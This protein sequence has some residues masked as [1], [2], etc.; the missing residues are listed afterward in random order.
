[1]EEYDGLIDFQLFDMA[2]RLLMMKR[3]VSPL[4]VYIAPQMPSGIYITRVFFPDT[5][6]QPLIDKSFL[7][8]SLN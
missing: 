4:D 3:G 2:G 5:R 1:L 8:T 6:Y 7:S